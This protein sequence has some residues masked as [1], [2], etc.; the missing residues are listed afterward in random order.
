MSKNYFFVH[1]PKTAG[2][3]FRKALQRNELVHFLYDYGKKNPESSPQLVELEPEQLTPESQLFLPDKYNFICGHVGYCKYAHCVSPESVLSIVRNPV[4]RVVSEYQHLKRHAGFNVSF[5]EFISSLNEQNKQLRA[6]KGLQPECGALI[7]LT[8]HYSYFVEAFSSRSGLPMESIAVN[9]APVS[10]VEDRFNISP[11]EIRS[12]FIYNKKDVNFFFRCVRAFAEL[13]QGL[14]YNTVPT[15]NTN[16]NCRIDEGRRIVGWVSRR[17]KDCYFIVIKVN[18]EKRV[19]I[20]LDQNRK[21]ILGKGLTENPVCGFS[22]PLALLGV[23][24]GDEISVGILGVP[25]FEK[26]LKM[27]SGN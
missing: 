24:S 10:D 7:G 15:N 8:S 16:W 27:E 17:E 6:L 9:R 12:A 26:I 23:E 3:S 20:S 19:V 14:G 4:E 2:T 18:D 5:H 25:G 21:D 1:I 13:V 22:Y 11:D